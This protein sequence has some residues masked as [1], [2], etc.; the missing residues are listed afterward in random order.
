MKGY[1]L[2]VCTRTKA[3]S[4][5]VTWWWAIPSQEAY[6]APTLLSFHWVLKTKLLK[7]I[8]ILL[9]EIIFQ[10]FIVLLWF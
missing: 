5:A 6:F 2:A 7:W 8:V 9:Y 1:L 4:G 3:C 10:T